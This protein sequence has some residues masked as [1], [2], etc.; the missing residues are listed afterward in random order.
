MLEDCSHFPPPWLPSKSKQAKWE[1]S[2]E[3]SSMWE[4]LDI[5]Q[6]RVCLLAGSAA[7]PSAWSAECGEHNFP[8]FRCLAAAV[9]LFHFLANVI[10]L[11]CGR[12]FEFH[13]RDSRG[14]KGRKWGKLKGVFVSH[15]HYPP[16]YCNCNLQ[17]L[18]CLL[19]LFLLFI[20]LKIYSIMDLSESKSRDSNQIINVWFRLIISI[21]NDFLFMNKWSA[22]I[23]FA[24]LPFTNELIFF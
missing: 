4:V 1:N 3:N 2:R 16:F 8:L 13:M 6:R 22:N 20:L 10:A 14:M 5:L 23:H 15:L 11:Y 21:I 17:V 12:I 9:G 7:T 19:K 18:I 24:F